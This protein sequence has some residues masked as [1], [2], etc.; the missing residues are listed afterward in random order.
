MASSSRTQ[1]ARGVMVTVSVTRRRFRLARRSQAAPQKHL[2]RPAIFAS[3]EKSLSMRRNPPGF[4]ALA[5]RGHKT[6]APPISV[7][8]SRR[9]MGA[10]P[11]AKITD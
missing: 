9:F 7:M 4:C 3:I 10:Y 5:A 11:K 8:N 6:A 2:E 1:R